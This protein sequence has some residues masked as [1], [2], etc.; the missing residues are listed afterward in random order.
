MTSEQLLAMDSEFTTA[1]LRSDV[2]IKCKQAQLKEFIDAVK[3]VH[4]LWKAAL[5]ETRRAINFESNDSKKEAKKSAAVDKTLVKRQ[6]D[7]E[8]IEVANYTNDNETNEKPPWFE[9]TDDFG[10]PLVPYLIT[11]YDVKGLLDKKSMSV[12]ESVV[13]MALE[14]EVAAY[15]ASKNVRTGVK[16]FFRDMREETVKDMVSSVKIFHCTVGPGDF[17]FGPY[18]L[19]VSDKVH[20]DDVFGV[21]GFR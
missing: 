3:G 10:Q 21:V 15:M 5:N 6:N 2:E 12:S 9:T 17:L 14:G 20:S 16:Q 19:V 18:G 1:N 4:A 13:T 8:T 11:G 7:N